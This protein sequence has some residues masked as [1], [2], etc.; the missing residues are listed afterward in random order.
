[1]IRWN[2]SN[3]LMHY[4]M[5]RRSGRYKWGSGKDPY[6][7]GSDGPFR[8]TVKYSKQSEKALS[9]GNEIKAARKL[10]KAISEQRIHTLKNTNI[11]DMRDHPL[12]T[13]KHY[14][15]TQ[16]KQLKEWDKFHKK[17]DEDTI[18][19]L[20][21]Q[22]TET[23]NVPKKLEQYMDDYDALY[24][25]NKDDLTKSLLKD[26]GYKDI[27]AGM[28]LFK[29]YEKEQWNDQKILKINKKYKKR[30]TR[31]I[32]RKLGPLLAGYAKANK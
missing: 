6:H 16:D 32:N 21:N 11:G 29:K 1:M 31:E 9:K 7:H 4:G 12:S 10:S 18:S 14:S 8:K 13:G 3:Y 22:A 30:A 24:N 15:E 27:D 2:D 19:R 25:K 23:G 28:R 26:V 20:T 17:Y 5:P